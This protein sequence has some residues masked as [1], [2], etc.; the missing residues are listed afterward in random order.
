MDPHPDRD[1]QPPDRTSERGPLIVLIVIGALVV[2]VVALHLFGA[3]G[4][5]PHGA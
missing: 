2:I 3:I 4:G 5:S 1:E